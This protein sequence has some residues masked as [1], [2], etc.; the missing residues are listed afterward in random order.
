M[1]KDN[2]KSE[3]YFYSMLKECQKKKVKSNLKTV[4]DSNGFVRVDPRFLTTA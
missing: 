3:L 4:K 2:N 1:K